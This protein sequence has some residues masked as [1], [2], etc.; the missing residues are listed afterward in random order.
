MSGVEVLA[1]LVKKLFAITLLFFQRWLLFR[2]R[3]VYVVYE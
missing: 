3:T 2:V 1:R